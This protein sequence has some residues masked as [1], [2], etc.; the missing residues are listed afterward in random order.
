MTPITVQFLH[1]HKDKV[2]YEHTVFDGSLRIE[3]WYGKNYLVFELP[4]TDVYKYGFIQRWFKSNRFSRLTRRALRFVRKD[5]TVLC[6]LTERRF[7]AKLDIY[8]RKY[9]FWVIEFTC[10]DDDEI[11]QLS[12]FF[13]K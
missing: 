12:K 10:G 4:I 9:N 3:N 13:S 6:Q 1:Q 8:N 7:K 11:R 2:V 5:G